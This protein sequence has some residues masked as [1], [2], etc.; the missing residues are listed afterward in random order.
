MVRK[1]TLLD[2]IEGKS[3]AG[4]PARGTARRQYHFAACILATL[5]LALVT[6]AIA[7]VSAYRGQTTYWNHADLKRAALARP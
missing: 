1:E 3:R 6:T 2:L 4:R 5:T 7:G